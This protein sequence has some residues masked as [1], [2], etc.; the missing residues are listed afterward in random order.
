M[1]PQQAIFFDLHGTLLVSQNVDEAWKNWAQAFHKAIREKGIDIQFDEFEKYLDGM[2]EDREPEY[3][4]PG[5]T[6]FMRRVKQL[7]LDLGMDIPSAEIRPLV[8]SIIRVWHNGMYLDPETIPVLSELKKK[9]PV[10]LITNWEHTP[11]IYELTEELGLSSLFNVITVSDEVG[12]A[13]PDPRVFK[14][15]LDAVG[16]NAT[17][18]FYVGDMDLDVEGALNAGMKP[19]LIRRTKSNGEWNQYTSEKES[20]YNL[21]DVIIIKHL[22]ELL[23]LLGC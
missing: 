3:V 6:L 13:K 4:E 1:E 17:D 5:F 8:D 9:Y 14:P 10:G 21:D 19:V 11:R 12:Y 7:G 15:A 20:R 23:P 16:V 2:F 22:S 18:S